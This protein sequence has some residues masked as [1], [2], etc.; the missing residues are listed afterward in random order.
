MFALFIRPCRR[1]A[2]A[3]CRPSPPLALTPTQLPPHATCP[4]TMTPAPD[5]A[6]SYKE[7]PPEGSTTSK[8]NHTSDRITAE[9]PPEGS[10]SVE[11]RTPPEN[12]TMTEEIYPLGR[13][14]APKWRPPQEG[15]MTSEGSTAEQPPEGSTR[16]P[17]TKETTQDEGQKDQC[18]TSSLGSELCCTR[19]A[20]GRLDWERPGPEDHEMPRLPQSSW[21]SSLAEQGRYT[22]DPEDGFSELRLEER[23]E[24]EAETPC[25]GHDPERE[26]EEREQPETLDVKRG[27]LT[28]QPSLSVGP[29]PETETGEELPEPQ[30]NL[31]PEGQREGDEAA[32][33]HVPRDS[34][35]PDELRPGEQTPSRCA[36][37]QTEDSER[38]DVDDTAC[39]LLCERTEKG[40]GSRSRPEGPVGPGVGQRT[41]KQKQQQAQRKQQ[42]IQK[43][44]QR[45]LRSQ[46][47]VRGK[48]PGRQQEHTSQKQK[49]LKSRQDLNTVHRTQKMRL[50]QQQP[51]RPSPQ[52]P[53]A[54]EAFPDPALSCQLSEEQEPMS[55]SQI[56]HDPRQETVPIKTLLPVATHVS[57]STWPSLPVPSSPMRSPRRRCDS[58]HP[59]SPRCDAHRRDAA[60]RSEGPTLRHATSQPY[61]QRQEPMSQQGP[62][63]TCQQT[64]HVSTEQ[65]QQQQQRKRI[66]KEL[67]D[68]PTKRCKVEQ[69]QTHMAQQQQHP[70]QQQE[71]Q[72]QQ[73]QQQQHPQQQQPQVHQQQQQPQQE[74]QQQMQQQ[75][76]FR[77]HQREWETMKMVGY[78]HHL[79]NEV[80]KAQLKELEGDSRETKEEV[81][82]VKGEV[83][84]VKAEVEE[85]KTQVENLNE[86]VTEKV[87][88][89]E[90]EVGEIKEEMGEVK[91]EVGELK[92]EQREVK[93]EVEEF[94]EE[95]NRRL[96]EMWRVM[97][98]QMAPSTVNDQRVTYNIRR[99]SA[100]N[101]QHGGDASGSAS[102]LRPSCSPRNQDKA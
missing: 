3:H 23:S 98:S 45:V 46:Q 32:E 62:M 25:G 20:P 61:L 64:K 4:A 54:P 18:P 6:L 85:L 89:L 42:R 77:L 80:R 33:D 16:A 43:P 78:K 65:Q 39:V 56:T 27:E 24:V 93:E 88:D 55:T 94:K 47:Q 67:E 72:Q 14:P 91:G 75:G 12:S 99:A 53:A 30:G 74:Q 73:Q 22:N 100:V 2:T 58:E 44:R 15:S 96:E 28:E 68:E 82:E 83:R 8:Q 79:E 26:E 1:P 69:D 40:E 29:D 48:K 90:E 102:Q 5:D 7:Q 51:P 60:A 21:S 19:P 101:I 38:H 50:R 76:E 37:P 57:K 49:C 34:A 97:Q 71:Q 59:V 17:E 9:E 70:Q 31:A 36:A 86:D 95:V 63:S 84:E 13:S 66:F 92:E 87:G 81:G 35:D 52:Q 10:V 11:E 41:Q